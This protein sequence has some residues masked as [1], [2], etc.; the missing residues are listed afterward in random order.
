MARRRSAGVSIRSAEQRATEYVKALQ[1][2]DRP[3]WHEEKIADM[4]K[5]FKAIADELASLDSKVREFC[6]NN[7]IEGWRCVNYMRIVRHLW[8]LAKAGYVAD[9]ER[10][11]RYMS[12]KYGVPLDQLN[13]LLE[14][15]GLPRVGGAGILPVP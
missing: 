11:A 1:G 4:S 5:N 9:Y 6:S 8:R 10:D 12:D 2:K 15:L 13:R 7:R 3:V 14:I